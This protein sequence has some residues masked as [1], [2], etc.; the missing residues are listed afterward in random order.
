MK[1]D[2]LTNELTLKLENYKVYIPVLLNKQNRN[3][4]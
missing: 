2:I 3:S 4:P 1:I